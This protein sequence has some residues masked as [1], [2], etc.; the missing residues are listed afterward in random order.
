MGLNY[1]CKMCFKEYKETDKCMKGELNLCAECNA[2]V[3]YKVGVNIIKRLK[4]R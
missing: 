1:T 4:K 3:E 2:K